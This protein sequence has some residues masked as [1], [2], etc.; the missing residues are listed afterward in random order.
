MAD[1]IRNDTIH[2]CVVLVN[3]IGKK[4]RITLWSGTSERERE[5]LGGTERMRERK[6]VEW[7][8][9][10]DERVVE[11]DE[12]KRGKR[13]GSWG[14]RKI[15]SIV[16]W[17]GRRGTLKRPN[18]IGGHPAV[19]TWW[20]AAALDR[21]WTGAWAWSSAA[22][23]PSTGNRPADSRRI[24]SRVGTAAERPCRA[25][26][27]TTGTAWNPGSAVRISARKTKQ[28]QRLY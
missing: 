13:S 24:R 15:L 12:R 16:G 25:A 19:K 23:C 8:G 21:G 18:P 11:R 27:R 5:R 2:A 1:N 26:V 28:K 3:G 17:C 22:G 10:N 9:R 14:R 6:P 4:I 7:H 20:P